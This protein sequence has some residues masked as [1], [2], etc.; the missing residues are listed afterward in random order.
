MTSAPESRSG[1]VED[2]GQAREWVRAVALGLVLLSTSV[3]GPVSIVGVPLFLL[4]AG[5]PSLRP[6]VLAVAALLVL[7]IVRVPVDGGF[8]Y[9]E[10]GWGLLAGGWFLGLVVL[11]PGLGLTHRCIA[12]VT[13]AAATA[14]AAFAIRPEWWRVLDWRV[15]E[16]F[17]EGVD[18]TL[19]LLASVSAW[20]GADGT[21][22]EAVRTS[23]Y[24]NAEI[25]ASLF[26]GLLALGTLAGLALAWWI[27]SRML[28]GERGTLGRI[29]DFRFDDR[30]IWAFIAGLLL[31]AIAAGGAW[32]RAGSNTLV[33]MGGLYAL[34]GAAV[35][36]FL[37]GGVSVLGGV[38][39][40]I[41]MILMAPVFLG[42]ALLVGL[43]DT[44]LDVRART[45]AATTD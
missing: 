35:L 39:I 6:T 15:Q 20:T 4:I 44:W 18:D 43:G 22:P 38:L 27:R 29:R 3:V 19:R 23:V 21:V 8:W 45:R 9:L 24:R 11:R 14:T 5:A 1:P 33:F 12:A 42:M 34:R 37:N 30:L 26:P 32:T 2:R 7:F 17:M 16:R 36:L 10:R 41:A 40:V 31:V 28:E 25:Q 13:G